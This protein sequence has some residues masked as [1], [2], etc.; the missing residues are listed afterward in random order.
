VAGRFSDV[1]RGYFRRRIA[2]YA[3]VVIVLAMGAAFGAL[4]AVRVGDPG[5]A[6]LAAQVQGL[7]DPPESRRLAAPE[8]VLHRALVDQ[9]VKTVG[10]MGLLGLSV[11][12]APAVLGFVFF[13]GFVL[14]FTGA[15]L[16]AHLGW[17]GAVLALAALLPHNVLA[18]PAVLVAG[19]TAAGFSLAAARVL[20]GRR[21]INMYHQ[22]L[23]TLLLL[24][25]SAGALVAAAF[26]EAYITP[27]LVD[28]VARIL[29]A[30]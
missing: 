14:G 5:R 16:V 21:D 13:R 3:G 30:R 15:F 24:A 28:A 26:L 23:N 7:L 2:I 20:L 25:A 4:A 11:I 29:P 10:V 12:G 8:E 6:D 1:L 19:A 9:V 18:V 27:V 22:F 17:R